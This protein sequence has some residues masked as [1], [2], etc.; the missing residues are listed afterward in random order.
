[1]T[2]QSRRRKLSTSY[3]LSSRR[4]QTHDNFQFDTQAFLV[5]H[6]KTADYASAWDTPKPVDTASIRLHKSRMP[7]SLAPQART[8]STKKVVSKPGTKRSASVEL[9]EGD[10]AITYNPRTGRPV[11][12]SAGHREFRGDYVQPDDV[13]SDS[14]EL[15]EQELID[16]DF[17]SSRT[18]RALQLHKKRKARGRPARLP[19]MT[20]PPKD[21][22]Q[23]TGDFDKMES[24]WPLTDSDDEETHLRSAIEH[25]SGPDVLNLTFNIPPGFQGPLRVEVPRS[26][27]FQAAHP[28]KRI[29]TSD[30]HSETT[31][32]RNSPALSAAIS[33]ASIPFDSAEPTWGWSTLPAELRNRIY[34]MVFYH[35]DVLSFHNPKN[36][37]LSSQFLATCRQ[38]HDEGRTILYSENRFGF[39]RNKSRRAPYWSAE[40]KEIG[41]KDVRYFLTQ[42]IGLDNLALIREIIFICEDAMPS[43]TPHLKQEERRF[44]YDANLIE[45][46]NILG[47]HSRLRT[48]RLCLMGRKVLMRCDEGFLS[49]LRKVKADTVKII[50]HPRWGIQDDDELDGSY[51]SMNDSKVHPHLKKQIIEATTRKRKMY[52]LH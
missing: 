40:P 39:E 12:K 4:H 32:S 5:R 25:Q 36:F 46:L 49:A 35:P 17:D 31:L 29:R 41:F 16:D 43:T 9:G 22:Y 34:R 1:M 44:I 52:P 28:A 10:F 19:S 23:D 21:N 24:D 7:P 51:W 15:S 48:L 27:F 3:N 38:V 45:I 18:R 26:A 13:Q 50:R 2:S 42:T 8:N 14:G 47:R 37:T 33:S 11:R 6:T 20:P 30:Y